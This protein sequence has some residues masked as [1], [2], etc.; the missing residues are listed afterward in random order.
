MFLLL[1]ACGQFV[2]AD[3]PLYIDTAATVTPVTIDLA[4]RD[5]LASSSALQHYGQEGLLRLHTSDET[6]NGGPMRVVDYSALVASAEANVTLADSLANLNSVDPLLLAGQEEK[7]AFWMN[8]Y[9]LWV[10]QAALTSWDD[11]DFDGASSDDFALFNTAFV[12]VDGQSLTLN[13]LE[14]GLIRGHQGSMDY[15]FADDPDLRALV[16]AW[17]ADLWQGAPVDAR[18]HVGL[19]C[20]SRSCPD[21]PGGAWRA[22]TLWT[23]LDAA[24]VRFVDHPG[25]GAGPDGVST[26]FNWYVDDFTGSFGSVEAFV[27]AYRSTGDSDVDYGTYLTYDWSLNGS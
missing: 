10:V 12:Q 19:N 24:A 17:H 18:I 16:E 23:D 1:A 13:M 11:P 3:Q 22:A 7:L 20:M 8:L 21:L 2:P 6:W 9:N 4:T 14:H 25:K 26:L 5:E 15:Y 27:Q